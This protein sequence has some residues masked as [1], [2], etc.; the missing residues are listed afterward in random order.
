MNDVP[1]ETRNTNPYLALGVRPFINC[2]SVRTAHSG[3]LMLPEV[4]AAVAQASRQFVSLDEL[5]Q[6]AMMRIAELT[7]SECGMV[8][9]GSAAALTLATTACVAGNDPAKI[10]RLPFTDG[11]VNR[12]ILMKNQRF[13]YDQAVRMVGTHIVEISSI[14]ELDEALIEPVAM[15]LVLGNQDETS[16]VK[17][18]D[19]IA[20]AKPRGIPVLVDA[21]SEHI[22]KPSPYL[23]RGADMVI[24]SG[25]K[26]LRGPQ[27]SGLLLGR[28]DLIQAAWRNASP[29]QG[30][31]R[32][33]KVS[34]EDVI[35]VLAALEV[36]FE[37]R[38][39]AVELKR[40]ND[41]VATIAGRLTMP[42]VSTK[43]V[44]PKG[45][46]KVP[47]LVVSWDNATFP[48][49]GETLR[50]R[51]LD[52]EP[53]VMLDDMA[54]TANA[55]EVDPFGLQAGEAD[56]VGRAI[57]AALMIPAAATAP[58]PAPKT[59]ISGAWDVQVSFLHG[60]RTHRLT[61]QQQGGSITGSQT[62]Q[63]FDGPVSGSLCADGVH[64][65]FRTRYEGATIFYSLDGNVADGRMKGTVE[66]GTAS[67][68]HQG[69][70]NKSQF[71]T[72]AFQAVRAGAA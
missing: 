8:T 48:F 56:Q 51:V 6:G 16:A 4:R 62:S 13:S 35:G 18:E 52:G 42:G 32:G 12:V 19:F 9:C 53:R 57:A 24:Y 59:D 11:W 47:R 38:D 41:D 54:T 45:V 7:G 37:H 64:L 3:S 34:K 29:H 31:A 20:R 26:F 27:T 60:A 10:L 30:F 15:I 21:A 68:H 14:A 28:K 71:G 55:V 65:E 44:P 61:L 1:A 17:L 70:I 46:V 50:L 67:D 49:D 33:M 40:W 36:W 2:A 43:V 63:Q 25:G 58:A 72:G 5:M 22:E 69:P 66:L 39:P 23:T